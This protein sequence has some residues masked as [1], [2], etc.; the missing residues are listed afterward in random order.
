MTT[1][2]HA[3]GGLYVLV[4]P[5]QHLTSARWVPDKKRPDASPGPVVFYAPASAALIPDGCTCYATPLSRWHRRF[6][7]VR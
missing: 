5:A 6:T 4:D 2:R 3:L 7:E 1:Y